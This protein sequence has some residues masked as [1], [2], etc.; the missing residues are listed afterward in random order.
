MRI[1]TANRILVVLV[2]LA[3]L[4]VVTRLLAPGIA[5]SI[6]QM[7]P[8]DVR[9]ALGEPYFQ[10]G[11]TEVSPALIIEIVG[12]IVLVIVA[13]RLGRRVVRNR[14]LTHTSMDAGQRYAIE[15]VTG[16]A[17]FIFG[18]MIGVQSLGLDLSSLA[19]L[20][21]AIG[22]GIGFGLQNVVSNFVSGLILLIERPI[23]VGD[24]IEVGG[25]TG[26]VMRIGARATWV[27]GNDNVV[28]IVP[29]SD[30][31][32]SRVA[33]W[34]AIGQRTRLALRVGVSYGSDAEKV[35]EILLRE[36]SAH[37]SVLASPA[38][39]VT[40]ARF[41]E[42]A[43]EFDLRVWTEDHVHTPGRLVSDLHFAILRAFKEKGIEIPFP[44][45][46]VHLKSAPGTERI[47]NVARP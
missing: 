14:V 32:T 9:E 21:G 40:I 28:I 12:L 26:D 19:F 37:A 5:P 46:D 1:V 6:V 27:R 8:S 3:G 31:V 2:L 39:E 33:N 11:E 15:V 35:R 13:S 25:T 30:F 23:K 22:V 20:G 10:I 29:N 44:Q 18:L 47:T 42:S 17:V 36:A 4:L 34:T 41:G 7:I 38:P 24:R 43:I 45:R 16:Y